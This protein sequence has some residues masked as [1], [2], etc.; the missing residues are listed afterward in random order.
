MILSTEHT[1]LAEPHLDALLLFATKN[2]TFD[3]LESLANQSTLNLAPITRDF[4]GEAD[5]ILPLYLNAANL[6]PVVYVLGLGETAELPAL[7]TAVRRFVH[8]NKA[9]ITSL[10]IDFLRFPHPFDGNLA[11]VVQASAEGFALGLYEL[12]RFKTDPRPLNVL[13]QFTVLVPETYE[14]QARAALKRGEILGQVQRMV[15]DLINAPG[16]ELTP[17]LF[18]E[19]AQRSARQYGYYAN[20]FQLDEIKAMGMGGI[21]AVNAGSAHPATLTVLEYKPEKCATTVALVGKGVTFDTGGINIKPSDNMYWMKCD[22][23]G[24]ALVLGA[25]EAVARLKLPIHVIGV[26]PATENKTGSKALLPGDVLKMYNGKTVE[27]EDTDA[28]GRLI[29]ADALAYTIR[30]YAPDVILDFATLTGACVT[31]LGYQAAGLFTQNDTLAQQLSEAGF[32]TDDKVWRLPLWDAYKKQLHS[33]IADLKNLGGRP[34]GATTAAKFL[35][36]FTDGH[37]AWAHLDVAGVVFGDDEFGK[38]RHA[39]G[40]GIRLLTYWLDRLAFA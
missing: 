27:V 34:A 28:E 5:S 21:V 25:V 30:T 33:D 20:V 18:A 26:F 6:P 35:E 36:A 14:T 24:A 32:S 22:M 31:A 11:E 3:L 8:K 37:H 29:L 12:G 7:R 10:A 40:W 17:T 39:T 2:S 15:M 19:L 9:K 38:M 4:T 16:N 1:Y 23:G 13:R